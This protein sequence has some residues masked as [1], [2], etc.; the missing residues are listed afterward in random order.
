[1]V[2]SVCPTVLLRLFTSLSYPQECLRNSEGKQKSLSREAILGFVFF[3]LIDYFLEQFLFIAKL[4]G[5]DR[6]FPGTDAPT[7]GQ[8]ASPFST[9]HQNGTFVTP[10]GGRGHVSVT[11]SPWF[12]FGFVLGAV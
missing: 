11:Q 7:H 5:R 8:T 12:T 1:M 10:L 4:S 6:D 9:P 2:G 3:C